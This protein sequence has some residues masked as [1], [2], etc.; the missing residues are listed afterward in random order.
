MKSANV[1]EFILLVTVL[2]SAYPLDMRRLAILTLATIALWSITIWNSYRDGYNDG[3][4]EAEADR[5][6]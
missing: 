3:Y 4:T 2:V 6:Y 5:V 1:L